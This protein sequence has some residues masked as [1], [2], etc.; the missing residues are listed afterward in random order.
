M[1]DVLAKK[2]EKQSVKEKTL[3]RV[4]RGE[5]LE[6]PPLWL[7]RQA[8]RYLPEYREVRG[9]V[10][11]FLELCYTPEKAVEVTLQPIRRFGFDAAIL[12]ADILLLPH[13]LGQGL[14]FEEGE[15]PKLDAIR[16]M[17]GVAGL[18]L[19]R[20]DQH[21]GP[22]YETVKRLRRE[23]SG[24]TA[25]IGFA[26]APWTVATYMVEGGTSRDFVNVK[27][28][29]FA[30]P[31]DFDSLI[32]LL[33]RGTVHYLAGQIRAGAE[34]IQLFDTWAGVLPEEEFRRFVIAPTKRIVESVKSMA[35][36]VP[37]IGFPRGAGALLEAYV[38]ETGVDAV[39]LDSSVSLTW[40]AA[41][42]Q[43][44]CTVQ[45]N[46]DPVLLLSGGKPMQQAAHRILDA[47]AGGP[48]IFNLGHGIL[49]MTPPEHVADL[50]RCVRGWR[51]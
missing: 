2:I 37:V 10:S 22:V 3:L 14:T 4:L 32:D 27:K 19:E 44:V 48:F 25:L 30:R 7:M 49:P 13:A 1:S 51:A 46:L 29:A 20:I 9:G 33:V 21:L 41:T 8:G 5:V 35:P 28:W 16:D 23:L 39:G 12:F 18:N 42:L 15:G 6:S 17:S 38:K 40:A 34:V 36:D 24:E 31:D 11:G 26:G 43:P 50:F 45:G 47:L